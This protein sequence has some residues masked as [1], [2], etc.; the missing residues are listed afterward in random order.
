[1]LLIE[2]MLESTPDPV[3]HWQDLYEA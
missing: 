1:V 3:V 2:R